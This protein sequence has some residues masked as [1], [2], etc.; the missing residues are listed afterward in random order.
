[1]KILFCIEQLS[2]SYKFFENLIIELSKENKIDIEVFNLC[3]N[4]EVNAHLAT[5]CNKVYTL[6]NEK[7]YKKQPW[8][9][10]KIIQQSNPDIVHAHEVIPSFY[11]ALGLWLSGSKAKLIFHR[12]HS[13]YRNKS[14]KFME[15]I[16]FFKCNVAISVSKTAQQQAFSEHPFAK[17]KILQIYNGIS[18]HD[19]GK[20]LPVDISQ[21]KNHFKVALIA[22]LGSRKG[23]A[24]AI[25]AIDIVRKQI[26][27]V[28]LFFAGYGYLENS[29]KQIVL[30]KNLQQHVIF[31]GDV[32]NIYALIK[33]ID[34][35]ILPSESEA[36][37]L[38]ILETFAGEKLSIASNLPSIKECITDKE[39]GIL[40]EI[41][42]VKQLAENIIF[43]FKNKTERN[44][45]ARNAYNLYKEK[46][47]TEIMTEEIISLY[48]RLYNR[49]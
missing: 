37:N 13:F 6:P 4:K 2:T 27:E 7:G 48:K 19:N 16:A 45:I 5:V 17:Q 29:L 25:D 9:I 26:P 41:N 1:M 11:A 3:R 12:H 33:T 15:R 47:S 21:F 20:P 31:L 22:R 28:V 10:K 43:Y 8:N 44:R 14:T 38:S 49:K 30:Q 40:I 24:T 42:N 32:Q 36:F 18:L 39:T 23:H 35:S 34:I 46:F